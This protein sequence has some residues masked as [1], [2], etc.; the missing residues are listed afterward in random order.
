MLFD[1]FFFGLPIIL[2]VCLAAHAIREA[3][4]RFW[5]ASYTWI[6][7][8]AFYLVGG[9]EVILFFGCLFLGAS[10]W[11]HLIPLPVI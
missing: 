9:R 2:A 11:L 7:Y 8:C 6:A 4:R 3:D 10:S 1:L 5:L